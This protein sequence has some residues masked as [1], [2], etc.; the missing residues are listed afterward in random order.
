MS[1]SSNDISSGTPEAVVPRG[2]RISRIQTDSKSI[3]EET[4]SPVSAATRPIQRDDKSVSSLATVVSSPGSVLQRPSR[5]TSGAF[6]TEEDRG[7][8]TFVALRC[9]RVGIG[10]RLGTFVPAMITLAI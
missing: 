8:T 3:A 2:D 6:A 5:S 1:A 9:F 4:L 10:G 7:L